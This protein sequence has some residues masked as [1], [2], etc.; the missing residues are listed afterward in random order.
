MVVRPDRSGHS[1]LWRATLQP[2]SFSFT[3]SMAPQRWRILD[4][5]PLF[6]SVGLAA[7]AL[8]STSTAF[9]IIDARELKISLSTFRTTTIGAA[10]LDC[11]A[12]GFIVILMI[13]R[14]WC[15]G[16]WLHRWI[17]PWSGAL[18]AVAAAIIS[19][20]TLVLKKI[21]PTAVSESEKAKGSTSLGQIDVVVEIV[22]WTLAVVAEVCF[23]T[24]IILK[25][26]SASDRGVSFMGEKKT[27]R[28]TAPERPP[29]PPTPLR[30]IAPHYA[31]PE[32]STPAPAFISSP[33]ESRRPSWRNSL[34][35][36]QQA[37][38]PIN[39]R[40][41]L[42]PSSRPS[43]SRESSVLSDTQSIATASHSDHFD[44]WD[45]SH[46][47]L[48][49]REALSP[50]VPT[51]GTALETI[52]GSRPVSPAKA[53]DGPFP[54]SSLVILD[55]PPTAVS[56]AGRHERPGTTHSNHSKRTFIPSRPTS[57]AVSEAHIHPLF[58]T[59]SPTPPPGTTPGT[60]V[61]ASPFGGQIMASSSP[62]I[63]S[64]PFSRMRSD[65][66]TSSRTASRAPSPAFKQN[67]MD[68][69]RSLSSASPY[70]RSTVASF[71]ER[72]SESR[73]SSPVSR[74]MTPPIPD[75]ILSASKEGL[76]SSSSKETLR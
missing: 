55:R 53:L 42:L 6:C 15:S 45:T 3:S 51:K 73:S 63:G 76:R 47:D 14:L 27:R 21:N 26:A 37:V 75:F 72:R 25:R 67:S 7:F 32:A 2:S 40:S 70:T 43:F 39:S 68:D 16:G 38:R 54:S 34:Q 20:N 58:R 69:H 64:R 35:S 41:R 5:R 31:L 61:I 56:Y 57:P 71:D 46:V 28:R 60:V 44:T 12:L 49:M 52:P 11:V 17:L 59:D 18:F 19:L 48:Q 50:T 74:S 30:I 10:T 9:A 65:S 23:Y 66:R 36:L 13:S 62:A 4:S 24:L 8:L 33:R 29:T 22:L 1:M